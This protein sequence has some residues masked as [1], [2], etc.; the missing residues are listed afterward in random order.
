MLTAALALAAQGVP[1]FPVRRDKRPACRHGHKDATTDEQQ[2]RLL[3]SH[4]QAALIAIPTGSR[5]N[6]AV[7]DIDPQGMGWMRAQ[8]SLARL[9]ETEVHET[10]RGGFHLIYRCPSPPVRCSASRIAWGVDIRGEGGSCIIPP[11]PGY[12]VVSDAPRA[13]WPD[14]LRRR[15]ARLDAEREKRRA[16]FAERM[17]GAEGG[18][19]EALAA[20]IAS[21]RPGER[22]HGLFWAAC[23][24][25]ESLLPADV[26]IAAAIGAGLEPQEA[27]ATVRSGVERGREDRAR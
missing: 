16:E 11:S 26:L 7:L 6:T 20:W 14:Y 17:G 19:P 15:L 13:P 24:A 5:T 25:G 9:P 23:R 2:L 4:P 3:F 12:T 21:L 1:T 10:P 22:N 8:L 27:I 18:N